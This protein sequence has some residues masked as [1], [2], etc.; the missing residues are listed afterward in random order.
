M[1]TR[2]W[3]PR[4][5][6]EA[7]GLRAEHPDARVVAGGTDLMVEVNFGRSHPAGLIDLTR[8]DE[9]RA[10]ERDLDRISVGACVTFARLAEELDDQVAL[11]RAALT[12]G[13]PQIRNRATIGG[14]V[15]TASP[16][17][18][19]IAALAAYDADVVVASAERG[20]RAVHWRDFF[21]GPK[22]T[23]LAPDEFVVALEWEP[24]A[25]AAAFAKLGPRG[26][27]VIAVASACVQLDDDAHEARIAL[28]SV[29]PTV[30]RATAAEE[31]LA[32]LDWDTAMTVEL[33]HAAALAAGASSPIDDLRG[34]AVYRRHALEVLV[35]RLLTWTLSD[36]RR[37]AA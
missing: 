23:A 28:G 9:L 30:L 34:S 10:W 17:G 4:T 32:A 6:D 8:I 24:V 13:S 16:A 20:R 33:G 3:R 15:A 2:A 26:A 7:L 37:V 29:G 1:T 11:A 27:M 25:G 35:R 14:N 5:L 31:Y 36:R 18:D 12:V 19:G 21:T 22:R